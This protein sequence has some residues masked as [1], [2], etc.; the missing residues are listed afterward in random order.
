MVGPTFLMSK[1]AKQT[2]KQQSKGGFKFGLSIKQIFFF[3]L[4]ISLLIY[5]FKYVGL[6]TMLETV[7][8]LKPIYL[9]PIIILIFVDIFLDAY[10]HKMVIDETDKIPFSKILPIYL[11]GMLF[12]ALTPG[13][14]NGGE[15]VRSY[16]ISKISPKID[17]Y[18]ALAINFVIGLF[19]I[20]AF[21]SVAILVILGT[22]LFTDISANLAGL[23]FLLVL[24]AM[25]VATIFFALH[26]NR[27]AL[28]QSKLLDAGLKVNYWL[29]KKRTFETFS[30]YKSAAMLKLAKF[31]ETWTDYT[32]NKNLMMRCILVQIVITLVYCVKVYVIFLCLGHNV[33]FFVVAAVTI[34]ARFAGYLLIL[35]G[36][37][38]VTEASMISMFAVFGVAPGLAAAVTLIDRATYYVFN[39]YG[40]GLVAWGWLSYHHHLKP[41]VE[42]LAVKVNGKNGKK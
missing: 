9:A 8:G 7:R 15:F 14:K 19:F 28:A 32:Q 25:V 38:G 13:A 33:N 2:D 40:S 17:Y 20:M 11:V 35:P 21:W 12:N 1:L 27:H 5:V 39:T 42:E 4:S 37:V 30:L 24:I 34:I 22:I 29:A 26:H 23:L 41:T 36:G 31:S 18:K 16:Y 6:G 3:L 10:R